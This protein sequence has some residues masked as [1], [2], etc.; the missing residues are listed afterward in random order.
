MFKLYKIILNFSL[1]L[2]LVSCFD[3]TNSN[4]KHIDKE[5]FFSKYD[6]HNKKYKGHYKVGKKYKIRNITYTPKPIKNLNQTGEAS[7]YGKNDHKKLTANG[8]IFNKYALTAAHPTLPLPSIIEVQNLENKKKLILMVNDRGPFANRRILDVS[9]YAAKILDFHHKG[10]AKIRLK[11]L[12]NET[13]KFLSN[14]GI[15]R[16]E[17]YKVKHQ[18]HQTS[19]YTINAQIIL[20]NLKLLN[21][22]RDL[23]KYYFY[24]K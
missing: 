2:F 14:I 8:E 10:K 1:L 18:I 21:N 16:I 11:Y 23:N 13:E 19:K 22:M 5:N 12:Q 20:I 17:G 6:P 7:W 4:I 9:E 3:H 15:K 24:A